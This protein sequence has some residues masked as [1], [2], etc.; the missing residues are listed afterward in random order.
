MSTSQFYEKIQNK[1]FKI[2]QVCFSGK[3]GLLI[4]QFLKN[5]PVLREVFQQALVVTGQN[6]S[7]FGL[8]F[9]LC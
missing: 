9:Q 4:A 2:Q 6:S 8:W 1:F 7:Q 3:M 5:T